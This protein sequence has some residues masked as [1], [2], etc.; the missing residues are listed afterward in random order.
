M[1]LFGKSK[2]E[3]LQWQKLVIEDSPDKLILNEKELHRLSIQKAEN[4]MRITKDCSRLVCSTADPDT[5][6]SRYELLVQ[7]S[8]QLVLLSRYVKFD[9]IQPQFL[10][11]Q[12]QEQKQTE[13]KNMLIR[14]WDNAVLKAEK[15][16]TLSAKKK[17]YTKLYETLEKY[18]SEMSEENRAYYKSRYNVEVLSISCDEQ[19]DDKFSKSAR[20]EQ[21]KGN[22]MNNDKALSILRQLD[23]VLKSSDDKIRLKASD[24]YTEI[25]NLREAQYETDKDIEQYILF[26]EDNWKYGRPLLG[27]HWAFVLP[28]LYIKTKRYEDAIKC[29]EVLKT[30]VY[31]KDKAEK[32]YQKIIS[33][34]N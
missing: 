32:Y 11:Q 12:L 30:N 27:S 28:D 4:S 6:F 9:G 16:S 33:K 17:R 31:F 8:Y 24:K 25:V 2:K 10:Y 18:D 20:L 13:I 14:S 22:P 23:T 21:V 1:G 29:I 5:F 34:M 3:L 26:W 7:H 15:L 19:T